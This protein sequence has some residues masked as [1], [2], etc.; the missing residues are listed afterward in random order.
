M[1]NP[2]PLNIPVTPP[3][4]S[5]PSPGLTVAAFA[6]A[7]G[8]FV[9]AGLRQFGVWDMDGTTQGSLTLITMGL[10]LHFYERKSK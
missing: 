7:I 2:T 10:I 5:R 9:A 1:E 6:G 8:Q 4:P 3:S